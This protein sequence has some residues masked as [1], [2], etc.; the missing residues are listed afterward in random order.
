MLKVGTDSTVTKNCYCIE[1]ETK[2]LK[3][4]QDTFM[5]TALVL[6]FGYF[7]VGHTLIL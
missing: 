5:S 1:I 3:V 4:I 6:I 2:I 7:V